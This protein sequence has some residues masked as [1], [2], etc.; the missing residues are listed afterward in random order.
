MLLRK[1]LPE[2]QLEATFDMRRVAE[3]GDSLI[4][5]M[6]PLS[7]LFDRV[8]EKFVRRSERRSH[9]CPRMSSCSIAI[10]SRYGRR[11]KKPGTS[12]PSALLSH[13]IGIGPRI[14]SPLRRS[15]LS[16]GEGT[17]AVDDGQFRARN[18]PRSLRRAKAAALYQCRN[19]FARCC[20]S[21]ATRRSTCGPTR[22]LRSGWFSRL[23]SLDQLGLSDALRGRRSIASWLVLRHPFQAGNL[24]KLSRSSKSSR[25][26][27]GFRGTFPCASAVS[28]PTAE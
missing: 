18:W 15:G 21:R 12:A 28:R 25:S 6:S 3:S 24:L 13:W 19:A 9:R 1:L 22:H 11:P 14:R 20:W 10:L 27:E 2:H 23:R 26:A 17:A 5:T 4:A 16:V 7:G 8:S